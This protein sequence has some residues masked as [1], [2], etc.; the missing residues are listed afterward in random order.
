MRFEG[1]REPRIDNQLV[2]QFPSLQG[3]Q[4][5]PLAIILDARNFT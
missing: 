3:G 1:I 5:V 4:G 2:E